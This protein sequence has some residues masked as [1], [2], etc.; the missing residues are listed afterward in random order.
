MKQLS[1]WQKAMMKV[2]FMSGGYIG[3]IEEWF[4]SRLEPGDVFVFG[5]YNLELVA[6]KDMTVLTRKSKSKKA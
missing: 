4:I 1:E 6:V 2:K 5:G 3:V